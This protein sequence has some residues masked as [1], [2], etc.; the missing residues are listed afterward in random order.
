MAPV[1]T[2]SEEEATMSTWSA[3]RP[4]IEGMIEALGH[5][6]YAVIVLDPDAGT[7]VVAVVPWPGRAVDAAGCLD[8]IGGAFGPSVAS[9][10]VVLPV[11]RIL[12]TEQGKPNRPQIRRIVGERAARA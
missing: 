10:V 1:Q 11:D 9:T 6:R 2:P 5:V 4:Y 3:D 12:L 8:A 7:R